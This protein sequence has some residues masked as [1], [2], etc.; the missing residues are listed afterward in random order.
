[1]SH[2]SPPDALPADVLREMIEGCRGMP[3][4]EIKDLIED[5]NTE[6]RAKEAAAR[7]AGINAERLRAVARAATEIETDRRGAGLTLSVYEGIDDPFDFKVEFEHVARDRSHKRSDEWGS[8]WHVALWWDSRWDQIPEHD[9]QAL[10]PVDAF[11]AWMGRFGEAWAECDGQR[12]AGST[13]MS[14]VARLADGMAYAEASRSSRLSA[15]A[16]EYASKADAVA[17]HLLNPGAKIG[18]SEPVQTLDAV[19]DASPAEK[20]TSEVR[21]V[22]IATALV[23]AAEQ[24]ELDEGPWQMENLLRFAAAAIPYSQQTARLAMQKE[25]II[26]STRKGDPGHDLRGRLERLLNVFAGQSEE[27]QARAHRVRNVV[28]GLSGQDRDTPS[29]TEDAG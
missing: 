15:E 24:G 12:L 28:L 21:V 29:A 6:A 22:Q 4:A 2:S 9:D 3:R 25:G 23:V 1:M 10:G 8:G 5:L 7:E 19:V 14:T 26:R 13:T 27:H 11:L 18:D 16:T 20:S 17:W